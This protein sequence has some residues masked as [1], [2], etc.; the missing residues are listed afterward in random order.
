MFCLVLICVQWQ[1]L[2]FQSIG[3][4][5]FQA[6]LVL[7]LKVAVRVVLWHH[8]YPPSFSFKMYGARIF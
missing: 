2:T 5:W 1:Y 3:Q 6:L 8:F 7:V 4:G